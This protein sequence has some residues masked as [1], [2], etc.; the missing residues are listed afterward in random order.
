M[1]KKR[2]NNNKKQNI[3]LSLIIVIGHILAYISK[4]L[5]KITEFLV[6]LF[7]KGITKLA[8]T[9]MSEKNQNTN[10]INS[11]IQETNENESMTQKQKSEHILK[12]VKAKY[13]EFEEISKELGEYTEFESFLFNKSSTVGI[14]LG[15]RGS[16]KSAIGIKILENIFAKT[17][18]KCYTIGF[19][20]E[21]LPE[22]IENVEEISEIHNNAFVLIDEGGIL[23]SSRNAMSKPNKILSELILIA[24]H[25]D[26]SILFISQ[27]SSNLD[28]NIIRQADY[29]ILKPASL[30]QKDFERKIIQDVY[31]KV[32]SG[33]K[34]H[35]DKKGLTYIYS[36]A[37]KGFINNPLPSFWSTELSKA[38]KN[39]NK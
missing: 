34:K 11:K 18:K 15:K 3:F 30:L 5:F 33:F 10:I 14:I 6:H 31:E 39:F 21:T 26:L 7:A 9:F 37:F 35:S 4:G 29:L 24:R 1:I 28:V 23:F 8:N 13:A 36:D 27:N 19:H 38:F 25:K 17:H 32:K 2:N 12:G 22:F 20:N 16:G